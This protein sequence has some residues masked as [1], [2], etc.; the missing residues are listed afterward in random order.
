MGEGATV[1]VRKGDLTEFPVDVMVNAANE[2]LNHG[3]GIAGA[4]SRKGGPIIQ[5]ESTKYVN[6]R[7]QVD[8]GKAVILNGTGNLP[9]KS[10]VHA[11]GPRWNGGKEQWAYSVIQSS[12]FKSEEKQKRTGFQSISFP[13]ISSGIFG[14]PVDVCAKAM[15]DGIV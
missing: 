11:V 7:G 6:R 14:V 9:C 13:A 5:E 10:I 8:V 3:G 4:I 12:V 1:E 15:F 2:Q